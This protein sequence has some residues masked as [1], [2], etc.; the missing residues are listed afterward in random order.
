MFHVLTGPVLRAFSKSIATFVGTSLCLIVLMLVFEPV[1]LL[2]SSRALD[3]GT[4]G[5]GSKQVA[6][7]SQACLGACS[8]VQ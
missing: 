8:I 5:A 7:V 1:I 2:G 3:R 6:I 4:A